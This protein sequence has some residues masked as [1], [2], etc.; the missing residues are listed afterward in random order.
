[1]D[2][3]IN[4]CPRCGKNLTTGASYCPACGAGMG[5]PN[6][7][8][9]EEIAMDAKNEGRINTAVWIL[10]ICAALSIFTGLFMIITIG[11]MVH[12]IFETIDSTVPGYYTEASL[13]SLLVMSFVI[14]MIC[15]S[16]GIVA[17]LLATKRRL[18]LLVIILGLVASLFGC[19]FGLIAVYLLYK[20]KT[21]FK[22]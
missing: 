10:I 13:R 17:A 22:D 9:R 8:T 2:D 1:M 14:S 16:L 15:A 21:A 4:F 11:D 19:I 7:Q 12:T 3:D 5:D 6:V 18:W 20:A